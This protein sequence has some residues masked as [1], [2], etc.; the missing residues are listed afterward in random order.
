[1]EILMVS[2]TKQ[3]RTIRANKKKSQGKIRK[4][5]LRADGTT[6]SK[7]ELFKVQDQ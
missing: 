7:E 2:K 3:T 1:M 4:A 6:P 5:K